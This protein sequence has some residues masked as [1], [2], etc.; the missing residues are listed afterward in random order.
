MLITVSCHALTF[1]MVP[2]RPL[3]VEEAKRP[4]PLTRRLTEV[5]P[6]SD[7]GIEEV[8]GILRR[9]HL[10][11]YGETQ[12]EGSFVR[13]LEKEMASLFGAR[14]AVACNS[15]G[16]AIFL[17]LAA[18]G[19]HR[20]STVLMNAFTLSPVPGAVHHAGA[21]VAYVDVTEDLVIDLDH[22]RIQIERTGARFLLLSHMRG[23]ISDLAAVRELCDRFGVRMIED[24]AHAMG[25][26]F[27]GRPVGRWGDVGC[28]SL[29]TYKQVNA[30]EGGI[31]I[32]DDEDVAARAILMTG[33]YML[34]DQHEPRPSDAV[35]ARWTG[36][37]PNLSMRLSEIQAALVLHQ[38][39]EL[40]RRNE[41]W[42]AI[43]D[44]IADHLPP[45][46]AKVPSVDV[47]ST[48]VPTSIQFHALIDPN[49][50]PV[51]LKIC[52]D[53]GVHVKWF[54]AES[55]IG[56]TSRRHHWTHEVGDPITADDHLMRLMDVRLPLTLTDEEADHL[57]AILSHGLVQ[58]A[59]GSP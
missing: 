40:D 44:R 56:F 46:Y 45:T 31:L 19:V 30:G 20:D 36:T 8:H 7:A 47:R 3:S 42:R 5:E 37:T 22:L 58:A 13:Q 32:T 59:I 12:P 2:Q 25:A 16:S 53:L 14:Y 33:C 52:K 41:R 4:P 11:R 15:G 26:T 43:H 9:G 23:H 24:A 54:G 10:F 6:I 38:L 57:G 29:Q 50:I 55:P 49:R 48:A 39:P 51:M 27:E 35:F 28:F 18:S 17:A 21:K 34:F 1:F